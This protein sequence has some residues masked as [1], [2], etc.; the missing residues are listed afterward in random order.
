[1]L[2]HANVEMCPAFGGPVG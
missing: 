1:M 2:Q